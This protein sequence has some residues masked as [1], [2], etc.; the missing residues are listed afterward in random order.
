MESLPN[1]SEEA[2]KYG[3]QV[4]ENL[5]YVVTQMHN[6]KE[7]FNDMESIKSAVAKHVPVNMHGS[8]AKSLSVA[9]ID[10]TMEKRS[11]YRLTPVQTTFM[12][13]IEEARASSL[14]VKEFL[15]RLK[16]IT[17]EIKTT[18]P[19]IQQRN[20]I[21]ATVT[22]YYVTKELNALI[23]EGLMPVDLTKPQFIRLRSG[24]EGFWSSAWNSVCAAP[25]LLW[26]GMVYVGEGLTY[27]GE[28]ILTAG[29]IVIASDLAFILIACSLFQSDADFCADHY[30]SCIN[31]GGP[32]TYPNS[33]GQYGQTKCD[34][35][36]SFCM[37]HGYWPSSSCPL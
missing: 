6:N 36:R 33:G 9:D 29:E 24:G 22:L 5:R 16:S 20:L 10:K 27:A 19:E 23:E 34:Q 18:V 32:N 11:M 21:R 7:N 30:E 28:V 35:C 17:N 4:A 1:V 15:T 2:E 37:S 14:S 12:E 25:S 31:K 8:V 3:K 13:K 26:V